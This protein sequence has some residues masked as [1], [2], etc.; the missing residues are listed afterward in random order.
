MHSLVTAPF[1]VLVI[2]L[3]INKAIQKVVWKLLIRFVTGI[4]SRAKCRHGSPDDLEPLCCVTKE[5][6][7]RCRGTVGRRSQE[8]QNHCLNANCSHREVRLQ[9]GG[10]ALNPHADNIQGSI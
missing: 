3:A 6:V 9:V 7:Y 8:A 4:H 5:P 1:G 10:V 2:H